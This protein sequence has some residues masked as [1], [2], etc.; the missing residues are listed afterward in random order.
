MVTFMVCVNLISM[1]EKR[2]DF[3][4]S[5]VV[6][7]PPHSIQRR[8]VQRFYF[9]WVSFNKEGKAGKVYL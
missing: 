1:K 5:P 6:K 4:G 7:N 3:P 2:R 9:L 8:P